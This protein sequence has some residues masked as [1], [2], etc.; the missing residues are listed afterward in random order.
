MGFIPISADNM[1]E[2]Y[3]SLW[4]EAEKKETTED[5][6]HFVKCPSCHGTGKRITGKKADL[7]YIIHTLVYPF[8]FA[9]FSVRRRFEDWSFWHALKRVPKTFLWCFKRERA[10]RKVLIKKLF[11]G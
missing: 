1:E 8:E 10:K 6:Y 5:G 3:H 4:L 2:P 7:L 11:K 9:V